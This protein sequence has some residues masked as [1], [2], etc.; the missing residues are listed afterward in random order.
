MEKKEALKDASG[1][2]EVERRA[3]YGQR[4]GFR[5]SE[6]QISP[7]QKVPW[8]LHN[9]IDDT[10]YVVAGNIRLFLRDPKEDIRLAQGDSYRVKAGRPHLVKNDGET[11]ATFLVLQGIGEYDYVPLV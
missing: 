4:P 1:A 7:T 9:N 5:I 11:S 6:L 3:L 10:F 8:H 2:Y